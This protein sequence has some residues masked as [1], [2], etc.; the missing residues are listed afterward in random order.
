MEV[1]LEGQPGNRV[2]CS[3]SL[4]F[5]L[6]ERG[7]PAA[8]VAI[9]Q[10]I[11]GHV[12]QES[13]QREYDLR[14]RMA[15]D[16][17]KAGD[18]Q[19]VPAT[20][21]FSASDR[22]YLIHGLPLGIAL[23]HEMALS[24]VHP[25]D[26]ERVLHAIDTAVSTETP[27]SVEFRVLWPD[28]SL[29]WVLSN[30]DLIN[31]GGVVRM[32]GLAQD[33]TERKVAEEALRRAEERNRNLLES[34]DQGFSVIEMI[35]DDD[36]EALDY[37]FLEVNPTFERHTGL[38]NAVGKT[39]MELVPEL[40]REWFR[41][42]GQVAETGAP[43]QF[44]QGSEAM[45]RWFE[46]DAVRVG[47]EGSRKVALLF[48]DITQRKEAGERLRKAREELAES[49]LRLELAQ[50]AARVGVWDWNMVEDRANVSGLY[51]A[52]MGL[53]PAILHPS[54]E[55]W[56]A[57]VH[58]EDRERVKRE[59]ADAIRDRTPFLTNFRTLLGDGSELH[60]QSRG[61]VSYNASG[62]PERMIGALVDI[63]ARMEAE[64]E[65]ERRRREFQSLVEHSPDV[66]ARMDQEMR[67]LYVNAGMARLTGIPPE[68]F[69]GKTPRELNLQGDQID[70]WREQFDTV[71]RT[72]EELYFESN[73]IDPSGREI[74]LRSRLVPERGVDGEIETIL[75]VTYDVTDRVRAENDRQMLL[76]TIAHDLKNPLGALKAQAQ[77]VQRQ[78][79]RKGV[80]DPSALIERFAG[81][82]DLADRMTSL[83]DELT[84]QTLLAAGRPLD[85][86]FAPS[87]L[88]AIVRASAGETDH[89]SGTEGVRIETSVERLNGH[90]DDQ[91]LR[92]VF[93]NILSNAVKYSP[94]GSPVDVTIRR[95]GDE[96]IVS[97]R[98]QGIGI[99][100]ADLPYI[101]EFKRRGS[102]VGDVAGSGVGLAGAR[103][104]VQ[105]HGGAITVESVLGRGS[106]FTVHLPI[107][108]G[109]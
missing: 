34:M 20:G 107:V 12:A 76:D 99:P 90:W 67:F 75:S 50:Q 37:R 66:I 15:L 71:V 101:F 89:A 31:E 92:R 97:V 21:E 45:G 14:L 28:G 64:R 3:V 83:V 108:A 19:S 8:E 42:Y 18:W 59:L 35:Y 27:L 100:E 98:D 65:I 69:T 72:G 41:I 84:D 22:A 79:A 85:M 91:R 61:T 33:I 26:R 40:E 95:H 38:R 87:D 6:D 73:I 55:D 58:P 23:D 16:A 17:A 4:S 81:F 39:A 78:I 68:Q 77:L 1:Q 60:I 47:G 46:V 103:R 109:A 63:T 93:N 54:V 104:I 2:W 48:T 13:K 11:S 30:A 10:D 5:E 9:I 29:H 25:G 49:Q 96:A 102:N 80:P 51:H 94:D 7:E 86:R 52:L 44:E 74:S 106:T 62:Q 56:L 32:S 82:E 53:D 36:G 88:V 24:V 70:L 105:Q 43:Y 57:R